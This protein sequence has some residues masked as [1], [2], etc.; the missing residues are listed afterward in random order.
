MRTIVVP[1]SDVAVDLSFG[2]VVSMTTACDVD[3]PDLPSVLETRNRIVLDDFSAVSVHATAFPEMSEFGTLL[4]DEPSLL[5]YS[6]NSPESNA[7][8]SVALMVRPS[9]SAV[10]KS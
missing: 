4:H 2:A 5:E 9:P 1:S 10:M 3:G 7:E 8:D 6:R